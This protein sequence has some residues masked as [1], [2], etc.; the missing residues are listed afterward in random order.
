MKAV[1]SRL[2]NER[3]IESCKK[4][5]AE[6]ESGEAIGFIGVNIL[7]SRKEFSYFYNICGHAVA[8]IGA[9]H[10]MIQ[11]IYEK[12]TYYED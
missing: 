7:S 5:L 1:E 11:H 2:R 3:A 8:A 9:L 12:D 10:C 4:C 6:L